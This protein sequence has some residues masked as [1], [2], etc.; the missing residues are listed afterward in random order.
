MEDGH[1][2]RRHGA[3]RRR[4][5]AYAVLRVRA[6][7]GGRVCSAARSRD[8]RAP[9]RR[10]QARAAAAPR[11]RH[12]V[13]RRC[14]RSI[15][16]GGAPAPAI[17][18]RGPPERE[19]AGGLGVSRSTLREAIRA[20]VTMNILVSRHLGRPR[21][22]RRSPS[23]G[24]ADT[25][26]RPTGP[27]VGAGELCLDAPPGGALITRLLQSTGRR[28]TFGAERIEML[29]RRP[30]RRGRNLLSR[31]QPIA[32]AGGGPMTEDWTNAGRHE[33]SGSHQP[34]MSRRTFLAATA[35]GSAA[36][37]PGGLSLLFRA[38]PAVAGTDFQFVE[39]TIPQLQAAMAAGQITARELVLGYLDRV[40]QLNPTL[41][42]VIET[43][44]NAASI[45]A[46]LDN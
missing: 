3:P 5:R 19:F 38:A 36:L 6:A 40:Q 12:R 32:V 20:L 7:A 21:R 30:G 4:D 26:S 10:R 37:L 25:V 45:A 43:N 14:A 46:G 8:R 9:A 35:A 27:A 33:H 2:G 11:P 31:V 29:G 13:E 23:E 18:R 28:C 44:P 1:N 34:A 41:H 24:G 17:R 42:A 39:K 15:R 22:R 16:G